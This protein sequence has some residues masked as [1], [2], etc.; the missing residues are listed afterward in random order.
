MKPEKIY[1]NDREWFTNEHKD[2]VEYRRWDIASTDEELIKRNNFLENSIPFSA[3][4]FTIG[5]MVTFINIIIF[6]SG[7]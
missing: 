1:I 5:S 6:L 3:L 2:T 4:M 7:K